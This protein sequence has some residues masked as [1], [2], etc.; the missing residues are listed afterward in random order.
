VKQLTGQDA[1]FL[2]MESAGASLHL[3]ALYV[4]GQAQEPGQQL[5]FGDVYEHIASRLDRSEL[6]RQKLVRPPLDLDLPYWVDDANFDLSNHVHRHDLLITDLQ[7]LNQVIEVLHTEPLDLT[8]PLWEMHVFENLSPMPGFPDHCFAVVAKYHHAAID[9]ASGMKLVDELHDLQ[10]RI[11]DPAASRPE[12]PGEWSAGPEPG[13]L[14]MLT[15]ATVHNTRLSVALAGKL[16][17]AACSYLKNDG[18]EPRSDNPN[19]VP[20]TRFNGTVSPE[21][22]FHATTFDLNEIKAIRSKLPGTTIN[23]VVLTIC[24]GALRN[25]L[26]AQQELPHKSLVAM[27]P[28]NARSENEVSLGGNNLATMYI[29]FGTDIADPLTR[30]KAINRE[31]TRAKSAPESSVAQLTGLPD[32]IPAPALVSLGKLMTGIGNRLFRLCNCTITNVPGPRKPL[33]F[34]PAE[35]VWSTGTAP[36]ID[37]MG[38]I[39][40]VFSY[41]DEMIFSFTSCPEMLPDPR[42]LADYTRQALD[43]LSVQVLGDG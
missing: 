17:T 23:D 19:H 8:K 36:V 10:P 4:Y 29:P 9:G 39:I 14:E 38:L 11:K 20:K 32:I 16:A 21:R 35:L 31:T 2:Y 5:E 33:Y 18:G 3:T 40:C 34:G 30:L 26:E 15:R 28:V 7:E 41:Q 25:F 1:S 42:M 27:V 6:F 37:G 22:V 12:S 24:G 43:E 13:N